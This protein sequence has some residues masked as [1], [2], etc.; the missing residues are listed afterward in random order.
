MFKRQK[1]ENHSLQALV[2]SQFEISLDLGVWNL[3]FN[4]TKGVFMS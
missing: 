2:G 3:Q 4:L 1:N